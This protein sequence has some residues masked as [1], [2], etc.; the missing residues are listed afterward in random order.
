[1][2]PGKTLFGILVVAGTQLSSQPSFDCGKSSGAAERLICEDAELAAL[3]QR[4]SETYR[5][6]IATA[7]ALDAGAE[8]VIAN[9][10][11]MQRGWIKG[12]NDCWKADYL[13][14]CVES[15]YLDR[16]GMLVAAWLLQA[17]SAIVSYSCEGNRANET[18]AFFFNTKRPSIRIEY[19]DRIKTGSLV[20]AASGA[21]Y[22]LEFG[23]SFWSKD[24]DALFAWVEGEEQFCTDIR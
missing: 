20:P 13:R 8:D 9:L 24:E 2:H 12:R 17:P 5:Q 15:A 7:S 6:A 14:T 23:G 16:E 1:M 21:K 11:A 18:T 3:D 4:L 19:G 22:S 10:K